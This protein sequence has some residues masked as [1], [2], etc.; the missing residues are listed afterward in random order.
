MILLYL[1]RDA[2]TRQ[3]DVIEDRRTCGLFCIQDWQDMASGAGLAV[4]A[5]AEQGD[6][7]DDSPSAWS[8]MFRGI[9]P[10]NC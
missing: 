2:T 10:H 8:V 7:E 9:K 3:V 4:E 1:L 5:L 6:E